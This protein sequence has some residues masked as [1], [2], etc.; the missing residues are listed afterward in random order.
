VRA[1]LP[2]TESAGGAVLA[3]QKLSLNGV[4]ENTVGVPPPAPA[5][6]AGEVD[7]QLRTAGG[8]APVPDVASAFVICLTFFQIPP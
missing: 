2:G 1:Y 5:R 4:H 6:P 3:G 8:F 7:L